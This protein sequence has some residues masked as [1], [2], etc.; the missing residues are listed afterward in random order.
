[1]FFKECFKTI[2]YDNICNTFNFAIAKFSFCLA[3]KLRFQYFYRNNSCQTFT[4][5][6]TRKVGLIFLDQARF[7]AIIIEG[8]SQSSTE[9]RKMCTTVNSVDVIYEGQ[10]VFAV[11]IVILQSYIYYYIIFCIFD[12]DNSWINNF[13]IFVQECD[14]RTQTT[15][16]VEAF[17]TRFLLAQITQCNAKAFIKECQFL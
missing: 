16:V 10:Q 2:R 13:F 1:M 15:F 14:E 9:A 4:Y 8:T 5:V 17:N 12:V 3:F 7:T 6:F 11:T